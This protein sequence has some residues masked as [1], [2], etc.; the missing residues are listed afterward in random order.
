VKQHLFI[1]YIEQAPKLLKEQIV[2]NLKI[3]KGG[4]NLRNESATKNS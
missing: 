4:H 2:M 3:N 1:F